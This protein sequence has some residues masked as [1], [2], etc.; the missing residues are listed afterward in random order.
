MRFQSRATRLYKS[1]CR[2]VGRSVGRSVVWSLCRSVPPLRFWRFQ[3]FA[4]GF[5]ITAPAQSYATD[6]VVYTGLPT[7][8]HI[9]APAKPPRLKPVRVSGLVFSRRFSPASTENYTFLHMC[10]YNTSEVFNGTGFIGYK[11]GNTATIMLK[12]W[13][14]LVKK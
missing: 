4:S 3:H 14:E 10:L 2:S 13:I 12:F 9:T 5:F 8:P 1:L 11:L 7:A 6:A